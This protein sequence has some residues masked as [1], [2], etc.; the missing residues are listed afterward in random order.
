V[1]AEVLA[2]AALPGSLDL[3]VALV[4]T[5]NN[6]IQTSA[7]SDAVDVVFI[8]QSLMS[9]ISNVAEN[10]SVCRHIVILTREIN[11]TLGSPELVSRCGSL[12]G[13]SRPDSKCVSFNLEIAH[14]H[15]LSSCQQSSDVPAS[16]AVNG[17]T[18]SSQSRVS[19]A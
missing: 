3:V 1:L 17:Y 6:V 7:A 16:I 4:Q 8:E 9:A 15:I 5:L 14:A 13:S 2:S 19:L 10:I 18:N 11:V 12:G